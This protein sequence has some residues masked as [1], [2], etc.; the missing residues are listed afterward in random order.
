MNLRDFVAGTLREILDGVT[1]AQAGGHREL[2]NPHAHYLADDAPKT[3]FVTRHQSLVQMV[4]FDV[5]ITVESTTEKSGGAGV[6]IFSVVE[7]GGGGSDAERS[8]NVSR[9]KFSVP[10]TFPRAK[11]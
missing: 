4:E 5:A 3:H 9:I 11:S 6:K 10:V 7:V 8:S 2:I 1:D